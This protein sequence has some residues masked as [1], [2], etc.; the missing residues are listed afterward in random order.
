MRIFNYIYFFSSFINGIIGPYLILYFYESGLDSQDIGLMFVIHYLGVLI[1]EIPTG[2]YA[3]LVGRKKSVAVSF[4]GGGFLSLLM[5]FV[6]HKYQFFLVFLLKGIMATFCSGA[7]EAW[8]AESISNGEENVVHYWSKIESISYIGSLTGFILSSILVANKFLKEL[9]LFMGMGTI[10][11]GMFILMVGVDKRR[12]KKLSVVD[13]YRKYLKTIKKG[14]EVMYSRKVLLLLN[15]ALFFFFASSGVISLVWQPFFNYR[16]GVDKTYFG[17][18]TCLTTIGAILGAKYAGNLNSIFKNEAKSLVVESVIVSLMVVI[19]VNLSAMYKVAYI[20]VFIFY[21]FFY[22][23]QRPL[24]QS[25]INKYLS[26]DIR[27]T[28]LSVNSLMI[29]FS[30]ILCSIVFGLSDKIGF[31]PVLGISFLFILIVP[32][33]YFYIFHIKKEH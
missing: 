12:R 15:F 20:V 32:I 33:I 31:R 10:T 7:L 18:I 5:Y 3:D 22:A 24:F 21:M 26:D 30:T 19:M 17:I 1:F 16:L 9:W 23:M 2:A 27:A 6:I 8:Y 25:L 13:A 29:G 28:A 4:L 14:M 11:L